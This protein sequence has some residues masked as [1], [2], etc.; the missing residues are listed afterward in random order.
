MKKNVKF[1]VF[2]QEFAAEGYQLWF[3]QKK[4][5]DNSTDSTSSD[6]QDNFDTCLLQMDFVKSALAANPCMVIY[7]I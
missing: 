6:S 4:P 1:L 3:I 7:Y 2:Q 5:L